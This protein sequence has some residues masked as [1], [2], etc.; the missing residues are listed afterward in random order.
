[1]KG[2]W[3]SLQKVCPHE[4]SEDF[5]ELLD[6]AMTADSRIRFQTP[7]AYMTALSSIQSAVSTSDDALKPAFAQK[8]LRL[9]SASN[10]AMMAAQ[11]PLN[12]MPLKFDD[13][14]DAH[15]DGSNIPLGGQTQVGRLSDLLQAEDT[16]VEKTRWDSLD[17]IIGE[18]LPES[19]E[20]TRFE[21]AVTIQMDPVEATPTTEIRA[22]EQ[23]KDDYD[24]LFKSSTDFFSD[25]GKDLEDLFGKQDEQR[26]AREQAEREAREQAAREARE[27][28]AREAR[29][30]EQ[31]EYEA[32]AREAREQADREAQERADRAAREQADREA[33]EREA[34]E[35][36]AQEALQSTDNAQIETDV[37]H[38]FRML[39][40]QNITDD[41]DANSKEEDVEVSESDA[42]PQTSKKKKKKR[43]K[44]AADQHEQ[45][46]SDAS[47]DLLNVDDAS[48]IGAMRS[49]ELLQDAH[50]P[51]M[52][53]VTTA[54]ERS[55][56][57]VETDKLRKAILSQE[58][59]AEEKRLS[60]GDS[61]D[62][63]RINQEPHKRISKK[64][65]A[66][67]EDENEIKRGDVL[68]MEGG[69]AKNS[70]ETKLVRKRGVR[71]EC[72]PK[73]QVVEADL[74][75]RALWNPRDLPE[76][77][78]LP[79]MTATAGFIHSDSDEA[80]GVDISLDEKGLESG[81]NLNAV[82]ASSLGLVRSSGNHPK[83]KENVA[84]AKAEDE[85]DEDD[86]FGSNKRA[87][88]K[89]NTKPMLYA[90]IGVLLVF[91]VVLIIMVASRLSEGPTDVSEAE[92]PVAAQVAQFHDSLMDQSLEGRKTAT[93]LLKDL[94]SSNIEQE[95]LSQL[96]NDYN[97]AFAEQARAIRALASKSEDIPE[98]AFGLYAD[99]KIS[100]LMNNCVNRSVN[101]FLGANTDY[102]QALAAAKE[103]CEKDRASISASVQN[104]AVTNAPHTL[105]QLRVAQKSWREIQGICEAMAKF[106]HDKSGSVNDLVAEAKSEL[107]KLH[108][109]VIELEAW[110][111]EQG[112]EEEKLPESAVAQQ[113]ATAVAQNDAQAGA[114]TNDPAAADAQKAAEEARKAQEAAQA[115]E[116]AR[117][118]QEAA[119]AAEEARK[120]QEAARAAQAANA[121][122]SSN[123]AAKAAQAAKA[124]EDAKKAEAAKAAQAAK[125][126]EEAKKAEAAKAAQA[127]KAAE[128]A[129]KAEAAK[130]AQAASA[131]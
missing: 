100:E 71:E 127:A 43:R 107:P 26:E 1:M 83:V 6:A 88:K 79:G 126:A 68:V 129:K 99:D 25:F 110:M 16:V 104:E 105:A 102:E 48:E 14:D 19:P 29:A 98:L 85:D 74:E 125:A 84:N 76:F 51:S 5:I 78:P 57:A 60:S 69:S 112:I 72:I 45:A 55:D 73:G 123:D 59:Q 3:P 119:K 66:D 70:R 32:R 117:K 15:S 82:V 61:P 93:K 67:E 131:T 18:K 115:A 92:N 2:N 21:S 121:S 27:Q 8:L 81:D 113:P 28:A 108:S 37:M 124:A 30:R 23:P 46:P 95:Q 24:S 35:R 38:E 80:N 96:N 44:N 128:E 111:K 9:A 56:E 41:A 49:A 94:R 75:V 7:R 63:M 33:R 11:K 89:S 53:D 13:D 87:V 103:A 86:W 118:A 20:A 91:A 58:I 17:Q 97:K 34:L 65:N 109:R 122:Q 39:Q 101:D 52:L 64:Q 12:P 90:I 130:A 36:V 10:Q 22:P 31:A 116:E 42:E 54:R 50:E 40:N 62:S 114:P 47:P 77:S 120:A 4:V 106:G